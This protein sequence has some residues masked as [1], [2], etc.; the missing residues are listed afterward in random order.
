MLN[1]LT[2]LPNNPLNILWKWYY[3][4]TCIIIVGGVCNFLSGGGVRGW[5]EREWGG[6]IFLKITSLLHLIREVVFLEY[7]QHT[8]VCVPSV[9]ADIQILVA[10]QQFDEGG[11]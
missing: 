1:E 7:S 9:M 3:S 5:E 11:A 2:E 10:R 6:D 4:S 8:L